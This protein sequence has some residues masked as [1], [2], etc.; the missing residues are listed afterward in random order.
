MNFYMNGA[1][2]LENALEVDNPNVPSQPGHSPWL[3]LPG[4]RTPESA[5]CSPWSFGRAPEPAPG[6]DVE[7][8]E[9][10]LVRSLQSSTASEDAPL[11]ELLWLG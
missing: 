3:V 2:A 4:A 7:E 5:R 10:E 11:I 1:G 8:R 9:G 6:P